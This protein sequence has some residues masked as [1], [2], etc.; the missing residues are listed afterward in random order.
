MSPNKLH[1]VYPR[2]KKGN[3]CDGKGTKHK[4]YAKY[5]SSQRLDE[6]RKWKAELN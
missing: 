5:S 2:H 1:K 6:K 3:A 4:R